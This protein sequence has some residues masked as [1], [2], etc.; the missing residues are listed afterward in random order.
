ML[1]INLA[2]I[3][4]FCPTCDE[5][6]LAVEKSLRT[7]SLMLKFNVQV[8]ASIVD[9]DYIANVRKKLALD[10]GEAA[11]IFGCGVHAYSR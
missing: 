4:E 10:Q 9:P 3:G 8:N 2:V 7:M 11:E 5:S 6:I 1:S